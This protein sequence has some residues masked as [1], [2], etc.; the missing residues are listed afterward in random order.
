M[1]LLHGAP[2]PGRR[3]A[4]ISLE[5]RLG[6]VAEHLAREEPDVVLLQ[7]TSRTP[8]GASTAEV[9]ARRLGMESVWAAANPSPFFRGI[10]ATRLSGFEEGPAVLSRFPIVRHR[11]HRLS[12]AW[13]P[14]ERRLALEATLDASDVRFRVFCVHLSSLSA[15]GR[16]RQVAALVREI[17]TT[18]RAHPVIVGGD[19]NAEENAHEVRGLTGGKGWLDTFRHLHPDEAGPTWGQRITSA[20]STS[21]RRV[22]FL[23]SVPSSGVLWSPGSSRLVLD[24][25]FPEAEA[26]VRWASDHYGVLTDFVVADTARVPK[27]GKSSS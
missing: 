23:F 20:A 13:N 26:G 11:A 18:R 6:W 1:N 12:S 21:R 5:T 2:L 27:P 8:D 16:R 10:G 7:E 22:D 3:R 19:F 4:R 9:I 14:I 24:Q 25:P 17:E 15:S